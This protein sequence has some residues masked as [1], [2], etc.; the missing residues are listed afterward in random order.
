MW[1]DKLT[2][3]GFK[4][5]PFVLSLSKDLIRGSLAYA[6]FD[7][8]SEPCP[9]VHQQPRLEYHGAAWIV[10]QRQFMLTC[11]IPFDSSLKF[12]VVAKAP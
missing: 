6:C 4:Y 8:R 3:N 1:F 11:L 2:T 5:L 10:L 7:S 9:C 12:G